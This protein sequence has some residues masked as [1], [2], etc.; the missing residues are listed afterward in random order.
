[1]GFRGRLT[2]HVRERMVAEGLD[3]VLG[4]N[5]AGGYPVVQRVRAVTENGESFT[6]VTSV[7]DD[8]GTEI[9]LKLAL[10]DTVA[11]LAA[12]LLDET[13]DQ[14]R[15][16]LPDITVESSPLEQRAT[17]LSEMLRQGRITHV[18]AVPREVTEAWE[19]APEK[20]RVYGLP[21]DPVV[22]GAS[23]RAQEFA[24][25]ELDRQHRDQLRAAGFTQ[26]GP[27]EFAAPSIDD[28]T[29]YLDALADA[30]YAP[31]EEDS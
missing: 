14:V 23:L 30:G 18:T 11:M 12:A 17:V 2:E 31:R 27:D 7:V 8:R 16:A 24:A 28:P 5:D 1:M 26:V 20:L 22:K 3:Q 19:P 10:N 13:S 9:T 15:R 4:A 25:A 6:E 21:D 29:P